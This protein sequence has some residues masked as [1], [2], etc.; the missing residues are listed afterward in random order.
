MIDWRNFR[1]CVKMSR[2]TFGAARCRGAAGEMWRSG[3]M[4][5]LDYVKR[6]HSSEVA[7]LLWKLKA[8]QRFTAFVRRGLSHSVSGPAPTRYTLHGRLLWTTPITTSAAGMTI[9]L[10]EEEEVG[11]EE[12]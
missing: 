8:S 3:G 10:C 6:S 1:R 5:P 9:C 11:L 7:A 4:L 2:P 12:G